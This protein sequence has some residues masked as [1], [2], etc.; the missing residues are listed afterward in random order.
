VRPG[1]MRVDTDDMPEFNAFESN[2]ASLY[3]IGD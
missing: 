3:K 2:L 1:L